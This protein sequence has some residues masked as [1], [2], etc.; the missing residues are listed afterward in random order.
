MNTPRNNLLPRRTHRAFTLI[1]MLVVIA[2][3]ALLVS[4]VVIGGAGWI[5]SAKEKQ[6]RLVLDALDTIVEEYHAVENRYLPM[7]VPDPAQAEGGSILRLDDR[8]SLP[9]KYRMTAF[10]NEVESTGEIF[11]LTGSLQN[12]TW[13]DTGADPDSPPVRQVFDGWDQPV[14][15]VFRKDLNDATGGPAFNN[16]QEFRP[17]FVSAGEDGDFGRPNDTTAGNPAEDNL[18]SAGT[19]AERYFIPEDLFRPSLNQ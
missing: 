10:L 6:T 5:S 8:N 13:E 9:F 19:P 7:N 15:I 4:I 2:I 12:R 11:K 18:F 16:P 14:Q 17:W 3:V 1:E